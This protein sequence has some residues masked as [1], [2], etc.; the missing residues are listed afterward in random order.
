MRNRTIGVVL[1]C[2]LIFAVGE[3]PPAMADAPKNV[4]VM[5]G[6]GMG[7]QQVRAAGMY[8]FGAAGTLSF[9]SLPY[10]GQVT[11]YS[12]NSSITDS[13]ASATAMATG[14]KVNNG[15]ISMAYPGNGAEL[16]TL[17]E[18]SSAAGKRTGL[19]T[20]TYMTHA[21]PAGFGAH[22]PSRNNNAQIAGD[23]LT[24]TRPN[25]LFG[26]GANGMTP[27][28]AAANGYTVVTNRAGMQSLDPLNETYVSGQFGNTHLPYEYDYWNGSSNGYD[29]LPHLSEM[30]AS[31]LDLL[32]TDPDG[33]FLMVEGGRIDH[34]G[35][36]NRLDRNVFETLEFADTVQTVLDWAAGRD[37]TLVLVTADHETGGLNVLQN[38]GQG[39]FPT[40]SWSTG[41]H[42]GVNVPIYA[43]GQNADMVSGVLDNTDIYNIAMIPEPA[44]L[45]ALAMMGLLVISRRRA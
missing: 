22:E 7:F 17:L 43:W 11:T 9:E 30:T 10:Q 13:A 25:V 5:I 19:V 38:N 23:Y 29:T 34:A 8:G 15:V 41:D 12:A 24:Q 33:M 3:V 21:T 1:L 35:H 44:T 40:V 37:D 45:G 14:H 28:A 20:T 18:H 4:I 39:V 31:A 27:A 32:E 42:T 26:G 36:D 2:M 6:D 16:T